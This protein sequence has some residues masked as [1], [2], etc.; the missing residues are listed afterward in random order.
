MAPATTPA[1]TIRV[2]LEAEALGEAEAVPLE[3]A[4][5]VEAVRLSV[6]VADTKLFEVDKAFTVDK[7]NKIMI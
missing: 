2:D 4:V 5:Q 7:V 6:V 1:H 3:V